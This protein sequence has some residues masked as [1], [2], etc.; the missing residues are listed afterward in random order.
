MD[1]TVPGMRDICTKSNERA[2]ISMKQ[3]C[4]AVKRG[5][6]WL[7]L[8]SWR[9]LVK[10]HLQAFQ[11]AVPRSVV[12]HARKI[13]FHM[14]QSRGTQRHCPLTLV[15]LVRQIHGWRIPLS[16]STVEC[17]LAAPL[18]ALRPQLLCHN[19]GGLASC[20]TDSAIRRPKN[21][22]NDQPL[23]ANVSLTSLRG[24]TLQLD[25]TRAR[26]TQATTYSSP[27]ASCF[28][29]FANA[30]PA[31]SSDGDTCPVG[32][33]ARQQLSL[34]CQLCRIN[35]VSAS[36]SLF[37]SLCRHAVTAPLTSL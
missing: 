19:C 18:V 36:C 4:R 26:T 6:W 17:V 27:R 21:H 16:K 29:G 3:L 14:L 32:S 23:R 34:S 24:T 31:R 7:V 35:R 25:T 2:D 20:D 13:H 30:H 10:T 22:P 12:H 28:G 15:S 9:D 11:L 33:T 5:M 37:P 1:R 8:L